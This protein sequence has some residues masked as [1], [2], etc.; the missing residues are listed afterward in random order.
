[1]RKI[2]KQGVWLMLL[3]CPASLA[4]AA[5]SQAIPTSAVQA[6]GN[7]EAKK[8]SA[9]P[10]KDYQEGL[11]LFALG[12]QGNMS[13]SVDA[14]NLFKLAAD[15]GH[16]GAQAHYALSLE[17]GQMLDEAIKYYQLSAAQGHMNG[18]FGLG[19]VYRGGEG[20]T[21]DLVEA[22]KW[23]SLAGEQGH[24]AAVMIMATAYLWR[25]LPAD[26]VEQLKVRFPQR[27]TAYLRD[28][29]ALDEAARNGPDALVWI[30]RAAD[31]DFLS[32][33]DALADAYRSG[34]LGLVADSKKADEI[35][36]KTNKMRGITPKTERKKS[37]LYR[38]L[39]GDDSEKSADAPAAA[40][41]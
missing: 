31:I 15:A 1:M 6:A 10:E 9:D 27:Y 37:A 32:A 34:K 39:R 17:R 24:R 19:S 21:Q 28:G 5:T 8:V 35:L 7:P 25:E 33:L 2:W 38:F 40:P 14:A 23:I 12:E 29:L 4:L 30:Q 3:L 36:A 11:R 26:E 20:V 13:V 18:Q 41:K 22:R 16:A